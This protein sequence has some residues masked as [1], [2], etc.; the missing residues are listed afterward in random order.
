M[1]GWDTARGRIRDARRCPTGQGPWT[2]VTWGGSA[3][4][5]ARSLPGGVRHLVL[6]V[7]AY[8]ADEA[9]YG[10]GGRCAVTLHPGGAV[11]VSDDGRG[12]ATGTTSG[13]R[14]DE[15]LRAAGRL[16]AGE[17]SR[18]AASWQHLS[19]GVDDGRADLT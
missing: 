6:E 15:A 19:V 14:P 8:A 12:T 4:T 17:L 5:W 13:F 3:R 11:S 16:T 2:P 9:E 10:N 7:I 1:A 18:L